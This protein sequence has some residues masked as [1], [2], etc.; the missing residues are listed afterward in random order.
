MRPP[1]QFV[2]ARIMVTLVDGD[3][4]TLQTTP[5]Y[6]T[7]SIREAGIMLPDGIGVVNIKLLHIEIADR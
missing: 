1:T 4:V 6:F 2:G 5:L 7:D 3:G